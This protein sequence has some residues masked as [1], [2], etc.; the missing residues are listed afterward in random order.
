MN[1]FYKLNL[2]LV[3][4]VCLLTFPSLYSSESEAADDAVDEIVVT[5]RKREES[6]LDIPES[7]T[8]IGGTDI[9]R[10]NIKSLELSLIHI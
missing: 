8:A 10:Q 5:A 9:A 7:V 1:K 2:S 4:V 3:V 6:L